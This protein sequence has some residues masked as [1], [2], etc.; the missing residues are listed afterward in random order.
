MRDSQKIILR[1]ND[2]TYIHIGYVPTKLYRDFRKEYP[3]S[4]AKYLDQWGG[5]AVNFHNRE[6][7]ERFRQQLEST[8]YFFTLSDW[9][10]DRMRHQLG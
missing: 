2:G 1:L 3:K 6:D 4:M 7:I 5:G 10:A 8:N 9:V